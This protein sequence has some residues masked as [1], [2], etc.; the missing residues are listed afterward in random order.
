[1]EKMQYVLIFAFH[2]SQVLLR[3]KRRPDWQSGRWNGLGGAVEKRDILDTSAPKHVAAARRE[4]EE[5]AGVRLSED[6]FMGGIFVPYPQVFLHVFWVDLTDDEAHQVLYTADD[7]AAAF[8]EG[9]YNRWVGLPEHDDPDFDLLELD[10]DEM[11]VES[12]YELIQLIYSVRKWW[13]Q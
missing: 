5:E 10:D 9:E 6:R 11:L 2:A 1:M 12:T 13:E 3:M 4:F 7:A 8:V